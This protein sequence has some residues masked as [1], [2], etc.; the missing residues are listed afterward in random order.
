[1]VHAPKTRNIIPAISF[2]TLI[3]IILPSVLPI[4][5]AIK[6]VKTNADAA[7]IKTEI[8]DLALQAKAKVVICVLS[9][10]SARKTTKKVEKINL[11]SNI[12]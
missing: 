9:P 4:T 3:G 8:W 1:M 10:N 6:D 5:T 2:V 7:P 11:R 12:L